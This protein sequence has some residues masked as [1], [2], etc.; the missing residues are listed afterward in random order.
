MQGR[1]FLRLSRFSVV[2]LVAWGLWGAVVL[3]V[4][5]SAP[6]GAVAA[7]IAAS[8]C[9][10]AQTQADLNACA[11]EE[12]LATQADMAGEIKRLHDTLGAQQ[13]AGLRRVQ[14]AWLSFRTEACTFESRSGGASSVQPM[15]QWQCVA[16][17]TRERTAGLRHMAS[18]PQGELACV[19]PSSNGAPGR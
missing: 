16:R 17:M 18:C 13:R 9:L 1:W 15:L 3:P 14:R 4:Q 6:K 5:A 10:S 12:F 11:Y 8:D 19:R 2:V 7:E